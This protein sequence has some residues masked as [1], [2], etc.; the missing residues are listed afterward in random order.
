M[1]RAAG[2]LANDRAPISIRKKREIILPV[3]RERTVFLKRVAAARC[4]R[5]L[6]DKCE[7]RG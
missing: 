5:R 7:R 1:E 2:R 4:R 3:V 6:S